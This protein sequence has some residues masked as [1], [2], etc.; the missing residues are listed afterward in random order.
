MSRGRVCMVVHG[1]Y[2]VSEPRVEREALAAIDAGYDVDVVA[3]RSGRAPSTEALQGVHVRRLPL[4]HKRGAGAIATAMEYSGFTFL[5]MAV[6]F[7]RSMRKRYDIVH[8]HNPPD[9]LALAALGPRARGAK[10]IVDIHDF[11]PEMFAMRFGA[12][13]FGTVVERL[14]RYVELVVVRTADAVITVHEPYRRELI[15]RGARPEKVTVVMNSLDERAV[16]RSRSSS[17]GRTVITHGSITPHYGVDV[18]VDAL[19]LVLPSRR[20][21]RATIIGAG[22]AVADVRSRIAAHGL[23]GVVSMEGRY[24]AHSEAIAAA[25]QASV[26]VVCN[27]PI[28]RNA[29]AVP[30]KLFEY[31]AL[32]VPVV[33][34]DLPAIRAHFSEEEVAFFRA[35]DSGSLADALEQTLDDPQG[36]ALR[37]TAARRRYQRYAWETNAATYV[38]LLGEL[39]SR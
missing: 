37:A 21:V 17:Q 33:T 31:V 34:A 1:P 18:L 38:A 10:F 26:G 2:P 30:T 3:M 20:D 28:P 39:G 16:P 9:F 36:A 13:R 23:D 7:A 15:S 14:M 35:G 5:A 4:E 6:L 27:R 24:I 32:G 19:A 11:A 12:R 25:A 22:D 29:L 8:V